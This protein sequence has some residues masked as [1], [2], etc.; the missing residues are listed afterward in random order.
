MFRHDRTEAQPKA[1]RT[2]SAPTSARPITIERGPKGIA[3]IDNATGQRVSKPVAVQMMRD[4]KAAKYE[5]PKAP[6]ARKQRV[7]RPW[8]VAVYRTSFATRESKLIVELQAATFLAASTKLASLCME[9]TSDK[10]TAVEVVIEQVA[11]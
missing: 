6:K 1:V 4:W 5:A 2:V 3:F 10:N 11:S 9:H 8:L 7:E